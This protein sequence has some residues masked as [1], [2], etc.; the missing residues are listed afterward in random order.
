MSV[1]M[2]MEGRVTALWASENM[3]KKGDVQ[4]FMRGLTNTKR[5]VGLVTVPDL[6]AIELGLGLGSCARRP[7]SGD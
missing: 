5:S 2:R 3:L 1:I 7:R 6:I 4:L